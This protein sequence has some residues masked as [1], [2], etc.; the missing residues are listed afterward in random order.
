MPWGTWWTRA[1]RSSLAPGGQTASPWKRSATWPRGARR[2]AR[3]AGLGGRVGRGGAGRN[4]TLAVVATN[5]QLDR[6]ALQSLAHAAGDA[7]ARR[8]VPF[9][10]AFDGDVVF[11]VST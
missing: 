2:S 4:T 3:S 10:T 9:G 5:A 8:I 11:A 6:V 7:L 1:G